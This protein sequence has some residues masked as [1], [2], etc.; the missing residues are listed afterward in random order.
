[1]PI[2]LEALPQLSPNRLA[3]PY[4]QELIAQA[5]LYGVR[6]QTVA[7]ATVIDCGAEAPGGWQAGV[8]FAK[9]CLGGLAE[10]KLGWSDFEDLHWPAVEV[11]TDHPLRACMAS[12]YAGWAL[13]TD[14]YFAIGSGPI[15]SILHNEEL[16][17]LLQYADDCETAILCLETRTAPDAAVVRYVADKCGRRPED[18]YIL[19]APTASMAGSIQ[20]AAR[21][22]ETGLHKMIELGYDVGR[23]AQ[24]YGKAPL[25]ALCAKDGKALGR[26]NDAILYGT[27]VYYS[28]HDSDEALQE[29]AAKLPS[30]CSKDHGTLFQELLKR[31]D[32]KFYEIDPLLFS[33]AQVW[34]NSLASGRSYHAGGLRADLLRQS[35]GLEG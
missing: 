30:C 32:N 26:T 27:T 35:F 4:V 23:V 6:V 9:I 20:I 24:G 18:L 13:Q 8:L 16:F 12:Q 1:M 22:V 28:L 2:N 29:L 33:P 19:Y 7:G 21:S 5:E 34:L 25:P 15:R 11:S 17:K 31:Y 10:V 3:L 14:N